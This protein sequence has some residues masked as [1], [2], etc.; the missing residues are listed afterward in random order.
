[1]ENVAVAELTLLKR[2]NSDLAWLGSH[3]SEVASKFDR[4]FVAIKDGRV[5]AANPR[6]D[7]LLAELAKKGEDAHLLVVQFI[8]TA[9]QIL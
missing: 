8:T 7:G 4:Q 9:A 2:A 5:I 1:M 3:Y 6:H